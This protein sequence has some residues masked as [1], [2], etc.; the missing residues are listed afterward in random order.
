MFLLSANL[1][2]FES[3]ETRW[4]GSFRCKGRTGSAALL[5]EGRLLYSRMK[6]HG[7]AA[8]K[9]YA[10]THTCPGIGGCRP[11]QK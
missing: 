6:W 4:L 8:Q 3:Q 7:G 10:L 11:Q 2:A 5:R 1:V 9:W